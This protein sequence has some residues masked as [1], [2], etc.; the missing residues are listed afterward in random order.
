MRIETVKVANENGNPETLEISI[1]AS[2]VEYFKLQKL[3]EQE[4]PDSV[5]A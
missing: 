2:V 5:F 4:T 1:P 3:A